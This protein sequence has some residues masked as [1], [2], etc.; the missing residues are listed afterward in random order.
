MD[1]L[2]AN[3]GKLSGRLTDGSL[4]NELPNRCNDFAPPK[5]TL[6][7]SAFGA[8]CELEL[9]SREMEIRSKLVKGPSIRDSGLRY[10]GPITPLFAELLEKYPV[11]DE[12]SELLNLDPAIKATES[13]DDEEQLLGIAVGE[14][15]AGIVKGITVEQYDIEKDVRCLFDCTVLGKNIYW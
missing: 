15:I 1:A 10:D 2:V 12:M 5:G 9:I 8:T 4:V 11:T 14:E 3:G 13:A 7:W 6:K